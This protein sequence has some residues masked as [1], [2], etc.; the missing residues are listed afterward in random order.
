MSPFVRTSTEPWIAPQIAPRPPGPAASGG[1]G[2]RGVRGLDHRA[3]A[4]EPG[5]CQ[6]VHLFP[7]LIASAS[8]ARSARP[9]CAVNL[10]VPRS[11]KKRKPA[12]SA[13]FQFPTLGPESR[14][15]KGSLYREPEETLAHH[16]SGVKQKFC[17]FE[18]PDRCT[19]CPVPRSCPMRAETS[20]CSHL[21]CEIGRSVDCGR[22][23]P[24]D[25]DPPCA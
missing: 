17:F 20:R 8:T 1:G 16:P 10:R 24:A 22:C 7:V 12:A 25:C 2:R 14:E 11:G 19:R 9:R 5:K 18:C 21:S 15:R 6:S 3:G 13:G 4:S 23:M